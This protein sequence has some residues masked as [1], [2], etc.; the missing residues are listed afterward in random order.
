MFTK[1]AS[2]HLWEIPIPRRR[3]RSWG[4]GKS[5]VDVSVLVP[6]ACGQGKQDKLR[7]FLSS[8]LLEQQARKERASVCSRVAVVTCSVDDIAHVL[9]QRQQCRSRSEKHRENRRSSEYIFRLCQS[10]RSSSQAQGR[11]TIPLHNVRTPRRQ[12][13][14][15]SCFGFGHCTSPEQRHFLSRLLC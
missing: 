6:H 2:L 8:L 4:R 7:L 9:G 12:R 14:R 13:P 3:R 1:E 5:G 15:G 10:C 11:H